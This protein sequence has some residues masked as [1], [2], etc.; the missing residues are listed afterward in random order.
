MNNHTAAA[1]IGEGTYKPTIPDF[2]PYRENLVW[3]YDMA[4]ASLYNAG[5]TE[6]KDA[7]STDTMVVNNGTYSSDFG[8]GVYLNGTDANLS[9]SASDK[10]KFNGHANNWTTALIVST[11][12]LVNNQNQFLIDA[13]NSVTGIGWR[14]QLENSD[15]DSVRF[16]TYDGSTVLEAKA[17]DTYRMSSN[18]FYAVVLSKYTNNIV[19]QYRSADGG[20]GYA[21]GGFGTGVN[22]SSLDNGEKFVIGSSCNNITG[23][24]SNFTEVTVH[25]FM[26]WNT[27]IATMAGAVSQTAQQWTQAL[28]DNYYAR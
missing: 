5:S 2:L 15:S 16:W 4:A 20:T 18:K 24:Y 6:V 11:G 22:I 13:D 12:T 25:A 21:L 26:G 19:F 27:N 8:G 7:F 17:S 23:E 14:I 28:A 10:Y 1:S 3:Y 9:G